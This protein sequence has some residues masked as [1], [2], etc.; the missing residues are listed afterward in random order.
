[1]GENEMGGVLFPA[2]IRACFCVQFETSQRYFKFTA[3]QKKSLKYLKKLR[4]K[5]CICANKELP[6]LKNATD[7]TIKSFQ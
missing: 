5:L 4:T 7:Q 6:F 2:N 1:M 3:D